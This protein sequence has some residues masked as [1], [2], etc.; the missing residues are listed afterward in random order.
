M[1]EKRLLY[2]IGWVKDEYIE[3]MQQSNSPRVSKKHIWLIAAVIAALLILAGC[4]AV[5]LRLQDMS[6]GKKPYTQ[7][8][9][10]QGR[11]IDP[12]EKEKDIINL[13]G[14][15][16][17]PAQMA[18]KEW[19]EFQKSYDP[20]RELL[21]NEPNLPDI[22][23][24]EEAVYGCYTPE[25]VE[26]L[27]EIA[28]RYDLQLLDVYTIIQKYQSS[29]GLKALGVDSMLKPDAPAQMGDVS[30]LLYA[31]YNFK[32]TYD[33]TL[34]GAETYLVTEYYHRNGY[35][36]RNAVGYYDL[37][38]Y[39]QW[40]YRTKDGTK[41]LLALSS[42]GKAEIIADL[43]HGF[44]SIGF[45]SYGG[46]SLYPQPEEII[47][48]EGL[49]QVAELFEYNLPFQQIDTAAIQPELEAAEVAHQ[50]QQLLFKT[51]P[52]YDAYMEH[53]GL[54]MGPAGYD[55]CFYD[56][57]GDGAEELWLGKEGTVSRC[58]TIENGQT[59]EALYIDPYL[60]E[61]GVR[62]DVFRIDFSSYALHQYFD[63]EG[64][65]L[66]L[67]Y[68]L[69]NWYH[70][71][72]SMDLSNLVQQP[73]ITEAEAKALMDQ[74]PHLELPWRKV[75]DYP[76]GDGGTVADRIPEPA[77]SLEGEALRKAYL[78]R[79]RNLRYFDHC[80]FYDIDGDGLEECLV[81]TEPDTFLFVYSY[82]NG[83]IEE[84][85]IYADACYLC[86]NGVIQAWSLGG[87][88]EGV[89]IEAYQFFQVTGADVQL[90]DYA[91]YHKATASWQSDLDGT[92]M[93][94]AESVMAKYQTIDIELHPV[95]EFTSSEMNNGVY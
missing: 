12:V 83:T 87:L 47:T 72:E 24:A 33:V 68:Y 43:G 73:T 23:D 50:S 42:K 86:D 17:S 71:A 79:V 77:P 81:G 56:W 80:A 46:P 39:Q 51:Y 16:N 44:L 53:A 28:D 20:N 91:F 52:D 59:T 92:P 22:P 90:I 45:D 4:V 57:D 8:F 41:L 15:A 5:L 93:P 67:A 18:F 54:W 84:L 29:I 63:K 95:S 32:L 11:Y 40:D 30:G 66:T 69:G 61:G 7:F 13:S 89:E 78:D 6:I 62:H 64:C 75:M 60:C 1:K 58:V 25:M 55:Y 37:S 38:E 65:I 74:Y 85:E 27:H 31:P 3:E 49:E 34:T 36:P 14:Y 26:K 48:K 10:D 70:I 35:F 88:E 76:F 2:A 21:T 9:D 19:Y 82:A 94:N